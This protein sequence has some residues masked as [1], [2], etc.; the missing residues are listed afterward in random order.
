MALTR[1]R[2]LLRLEGCLWLF[3]QSTYMLA[4]VALPAWLVAAP[5]AQP[6]RLVAMLLA[7]ALFGGLVQ[8]VNDV[9]DREADAVTAP[10]LP[11]PSGLVT[12]PQAV[13]TA[14]VTGMLVVAALGV[15]AETLIRFGVAAGCL[16]GVLLILIAYSTLKRFTLLG[17]LAHGVMTALV[18]A[19]AWQAA[20]GGQGRDAALVLGFVL[21][22]GVANNLHSGLRDID[23][24]GVVGNRTFAVRMGGRRTLLAVAGLDLAGAT[25][26]VPLAVGRETLPVMLPLLLV[27]IG[28]RWWALRGLLPRIERAGLT[29]AERLA[30]L[31]NVTLSRLV[32]TVLATVALA[33]LL[34][35]VVTAVMA[36][37]M[38]LLM[39]GYGRRV[40]G[41][42]L[43]AALDA[44]MPTSSTTA[45]HRS[46]GSSGSG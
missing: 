5:S 45:G 4:L 41:G 24:D 42:G 26:L 32:T 11:L 14:V 36:G 10:Y 27:G 9:L 8:V 22:L 23:R 39:R 16:V 18:G 34:A 29:R 35:L 6:V 7:I 43:R 30:G 19:S 20:G 40:I 25:L 15:A 37:V 13:A 28:W 12:V 1:M 17:P 3:R 21:V 44:S 38:V 31:T 46:E 2:M 33:P